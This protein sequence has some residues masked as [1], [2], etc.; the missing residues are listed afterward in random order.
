MKKITIKEVAK[1][2]GVSIATISRVLNGK[3]RVK[4]QTRQKIEEAIRRLDFQPDQTAR[5]MIKKET[6]TIGLIVPQLSNEYW[7]LL[8]EVMQEKLW[9]MGYSLIACSTQ[10]NV[11]KEQAFLK[12][13]LEKKVDGII[14]GSTSFSAEDMSPL[15][16]LREREIPVVSMTQRIPGVNCVVGDHL[17]GA[18]DAVEHLISLGHQRIAYLGGPHVTHDRELG[19]LNAMFMHQLAVDDA[20][21][22]RD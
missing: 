22:K 12:T 2:A 8:A 4:L 15:Q 5:S 3:D 10:N 14:Y 17:Q 13:L 21:I 7:A 20:L 9:D 16:A 18:K 1:E 11:E 19:Y 6:K